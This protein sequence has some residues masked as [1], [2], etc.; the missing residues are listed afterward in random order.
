GHRVDIHPAPGT[1]SGPVATGEALGVASD[2]A[3]R[4]RIEDG[5]ERS[6]HSGEA[7]IRRHGGP[8]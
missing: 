2:G 5:T 4:V 3:L 6:F 7:S 1:G 8:A